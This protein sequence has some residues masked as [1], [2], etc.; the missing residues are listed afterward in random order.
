MTSKWIIFS[1]MIAKHKEDEHEV[2]DPWGRPGAGAPIR[3]QSGNV[4]AD[5]KKMHQVDWT[6]SEIRDYND[7][8][9]HVVK[10]FSCTSMYY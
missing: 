8:T 4:V 2:Y 5:Y 1:C 3:T 7:M 10:I 6:A 9:L